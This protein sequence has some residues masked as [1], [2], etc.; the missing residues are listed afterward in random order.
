MPEYASWGSQERLPTNID[1]AYRLVIGKRGEVSGAG[2]SREGEP[3]L[4]L[5]QIRY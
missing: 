1:G 4:Y 3:R 5:L 2:R